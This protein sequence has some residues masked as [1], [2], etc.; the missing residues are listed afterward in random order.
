MTSRRQCPRG[1]GVLNCV[2]NVLFTPSP[3]SGNPVSAPAMV[4]VIRVISIDILYNVISMAE[5][6]NLLS[7][8]SIILSLLKLKLKTKTPIYIMCSSICR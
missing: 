1:G 4:Y 8:K 5:T 7:A 6:Q 2:V 3:P